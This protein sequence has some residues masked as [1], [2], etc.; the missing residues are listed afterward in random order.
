MPAVP[1]LAFAAVCALLV[2]AAAR[3]ARALSLSGAVAAAC[4]GWAVFGFAGG[5]GAIALLLFFVSSSLLS[6]VGK[7]RKAALLYEK[8][9]ERDALQVLANGGVA[10]LCAVAVPFAAPYLW[11]VAAFLGALASANAD[12]WA[13]ELGSLAKGSPRLITNLRPAPTGASGAISL[14]GTLAAVAGAVV[15]GV[16][17]LAW[18]GSPRDILAVAGGGVFGALFDSLLG[19]TVQAQYRC[20]ICGKLTERLSHCDN[21]PTEKARGVAWMNNDA[22]NALATLGGAIVAAALAG[23]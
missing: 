17:V 12:T 1:H 19:A 21:A 5:R 15:I 20:H 6:R 4:V 16:M 14:P 9:G 7:K 8:G 22:V 23:R 2:V 11:A 10:A 13:T 3:K 18:N